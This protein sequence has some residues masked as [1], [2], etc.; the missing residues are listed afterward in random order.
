MELVKTV[1]FPPGWFF[2][3]GGADGK[4]EGWGEKT[5]KGKLPCPTKIMTKE[6]G[7]NRKSG[8]A[9]GEKKEAHKVEK[10]GGEVKK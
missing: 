2:H 8:A 7:R 4:P 5:E 3:R 10:G 6:K 1:N 9:T